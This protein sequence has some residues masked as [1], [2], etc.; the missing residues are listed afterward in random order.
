LIFYPDE[1]ALEE[2][3]ER[4]VFA[5]GDGMGIVSPLYPLISNLSVL[6]NVALIKEYH[7]R[8]PRKKAEGVTWAYLEKMG[9]VEIGN[10]R[11]PALSPKERFVAMVLR[12]AFMEGELVV[13]DRPF[14]LMPAVN[15]ADFV[16][17]TLQVVED[18]FNQGI[19]LDYVWNT[20]RYEGIGHEEAVH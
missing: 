17:N 16:I 3:R 9:M 10:K 7:A 13:I 19:I 6:Q 15:T 2:E 18:L 12:A 8:W 4:H 20:D 14:V 11:N 5:I 1:P